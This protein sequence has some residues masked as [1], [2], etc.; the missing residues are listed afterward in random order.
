M[1]I[2]NHIRSN[3]IGYLALFFALTGSAV[4]LD[5][6]N[7]VFSDDIVNGEVKAA[8]IGT[9]EVGPADLLDGG[10]HAADLAAN[11]V[12]NSKIATD[13]VLN[14]EIGTDAVNT[15]EIVNNSI[16]SGD[17]RNG[18]LIGDDVQDGGLTGADV[19]DDSL[20]NTDLT[21]AFGRDE[22]TFQTIPGDGSSAE[23]TRVSIT[24]HATG[25][26]LARAVGY[27]NM[28]PQDIAAGVEYQVQVGIGPDAASAGG[29]DFQNH[30]LIGLQ[31]GDAGPV[32]HQYTAEEVFPATAGVPLD[33]G[34]FGYDGFAAS[35]AHTSDC[36]AALTLQELPDTAVEPAK[37]GAGA[38][39][40][41]NGT[42]LK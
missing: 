26:V 30:G 8:D 4:A 35:S 16:R 6:S 42:G 1:R 9:G 25:S 27:C 21:S 38:S 31:G 24:P 10:V 14:D 23:L 39:S 37:L 20:T 36:S 32:Q 17:V 34:A 3:I 40:G 2:R 29:L 13:A 22:A 12:D 19:A 15:D 18:T 5:G 41:K 33:L 28:Y 11:S 7:T